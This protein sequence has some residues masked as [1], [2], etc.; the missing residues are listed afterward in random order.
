MIHEMLMY[1]FFLRIIFL[2]KIKIEERVIQ[3]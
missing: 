3:T 1:A 2:E